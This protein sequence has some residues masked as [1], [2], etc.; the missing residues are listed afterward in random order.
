MLSKTETPERDVRFVLDKIVTDLH[1]KNMTVISKKMSYAYLESIK[2][3]LK[4]ELDVEDGFEP[5]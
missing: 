4:S 2:D 5:F 1:N 3:A